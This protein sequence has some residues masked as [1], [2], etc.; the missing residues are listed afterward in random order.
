M[1]VD[2]PGEHQHVD[3]CGFSAQQSPRAGIGRGP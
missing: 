1:G 3:L 2:N